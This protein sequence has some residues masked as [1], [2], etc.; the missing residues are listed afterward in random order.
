MKLIQALLENVFNEN[1][2][3]NVISVSITMSSTTHCSTIQKCS[4]CGGDMTT[5]E[6]TPPL[7]LAEALL[8][9]AKYTTKGSYTH[10]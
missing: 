9:S 10:T 3:R 8:H 5:I 7:P 4:M 2:V 6:F 1:G